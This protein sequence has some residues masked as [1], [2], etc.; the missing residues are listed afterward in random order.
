MKQAL[1]VLAAGAIYFALAY[2][3]VGYAFGAAPGF[4]WAKESFGPLAGTRIWS[5]SV[6]AVV[7]LIAAI[8]SALVLGLL[9]RPDALRLA[10]VT[11]VLVAVASSLPSFLHPAVQPYLDTDFYV[12]TGIDGLKMVLVLVLLTWLFGK[13]PSNY[14]MQRSSRVGT[15]LAGSGRGAY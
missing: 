3:L 12:T 5:H 8:P 7:L 4:A 6:H 15:P 2:F 1:I 14:A 9:G 13:L 11:G 10:V